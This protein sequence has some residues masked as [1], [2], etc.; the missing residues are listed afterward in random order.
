MTLTAGSL[1]APGLALADPS[2]FDGPNNASSNNTQS[3][4]DAPNAGVAALSGPSSG[5]SAAYAD[6][7]PALGTGGLAN[8]SPLA[9]VATQDGTKSSYGAAV[10]TSGDDGTVKKIAL[11]GNSVGPAIVAAPQWLADPASVAPAEQK[12][13][14]FAVTEASSSSSDSG[15]AAP[16]AE[17]SA[18]EPTSG[19]STYLKPSPDFSPGAQESAGFGPQDRGTTPTPE[20]APTHP[21]METAGFAPHNKGK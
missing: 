10:N 17:L 5:P 1:I 6:A 3:I 15:S 20:P 19:P 13:P 21:V 2:G 4:A 8:A 7:K 14:S 18:L 12:F 11:D 16:G 9:T